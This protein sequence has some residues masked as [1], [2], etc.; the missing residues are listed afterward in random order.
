MQEFREA[1]GRGG[2]LMAQKRVLLIGVDPTLVD[3]NPSRGLNAEKVMAAGNEASAR[4]TTLGYEVQTRIVDLG[5]TAESV[6]VEALAQNTFDCIM[7]GAGVRALPEHTLL[8]EKVI[9]V[10]HQNAPSAKLCFNTTPGDTV[11]A[12]LRWVRPGA[13][14][15]RGIRTARA[16]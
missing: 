16:G 3:F 9:N 6:V 14:V 7:I 8:F 1:T 13:P 4:L 15:V 11:E 5:A 2:M 10:V 12:V